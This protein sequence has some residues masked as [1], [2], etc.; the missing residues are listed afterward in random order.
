MIDLEESQ[1]KLMSQPRLLKYICNVPST[2]PEHAEVHRHV[3]R[4]LANFALY[5][6]YNY[7]MT[8]RIAKANCY[9]YSC[10]ARG[11]QWIDACICNRW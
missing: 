4:C 9:F 1:T 11:K 5:G 2:F 6:M 10:F 8:F 7:T 3:A